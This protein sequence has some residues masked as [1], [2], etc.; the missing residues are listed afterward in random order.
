MKGVVFTEF[1]ELVEIKFGMQMVDDIITASDLESGGAYTAVGTYKFGEMVSLLTQL[2]NRTQL[3]IDDLLYTYAQHFF[4]VIKSSYPGFLESYS[5]PIEM[6]SSIE[7]HI[8]VEV[9][10]I[11][12]DA[13]LPTFKTLEKSENTLTLDYLSSRAMY[14]FGLGL[15]HETFKFFNIDF[16]IRLEKLKED[17]THVRFFIERKNGYSKSR[18]L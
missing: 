1:L 13:Q 5:D 18:S 17:G 7:D 3:S 11:Y 2:S 15:M 14:S 4:T 8:H 12:P 10:K 6:L 16:N 9:L